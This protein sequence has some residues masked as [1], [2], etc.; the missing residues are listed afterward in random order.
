[1][2]QSSNR[3]INQKQL[4]LRLKNHNLKRIMK[5]NLFIFQIFTYISPKLLVPRCKIQIRVL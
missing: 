5:Q 4:V 2:Q 3:E 1:M